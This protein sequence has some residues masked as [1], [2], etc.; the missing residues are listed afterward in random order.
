MNN[1]KPIAQ[2]MAK[3]KRLRFSVLKQHNSK[4]TS[5][6]YCICGLK[7]RGPNHDQGVHHRQRMN[8]L[9][10]KKGA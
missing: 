6:K 10:T 8:K 7:I 3:V 1:E 4:R 2:R 9:K 5:D